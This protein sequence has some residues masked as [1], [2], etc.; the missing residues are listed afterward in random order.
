MWAF[1]KLQA[2]AKDYRENGLP[3]SVPIEMVSW[4]FGVVSG[5]F[6]RPKR[7]PGRPGKQGLA[8]VR[9][10]RAIIATV[11]WLVGRGGTRV[12]AMKVVG[13]AANLSDKHIDSI[14]GESSFHEAKAR[15]SPE[16][17]M[18]LLRSLGNSGY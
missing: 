4:C 3:G 11:A 12:E 6:E 14:V 8:D 16:A 15:Y 5:A 7:R 18:R 10:N 13:A 9:R 2:I 1:D 17:T